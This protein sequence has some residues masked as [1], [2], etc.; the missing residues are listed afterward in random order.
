M[1]AGGRRA[2]FCDRASQLQAG[3][4]AHGALWCTL[5]STPPHP[6]GCC[7]LVVQYTTGR[8]ARRLE[9]GGDSGTAGSAVL[10][11]AASCSRRRLQCDPAFST[12]P[13]GSTPGRTQAEQSKWLLVELARPGLRT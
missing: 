6:P 3:C 12:R 9:Q 11:T 2:A 5:L 13:A 10:A 7:R 8:V 1:Q 4:W